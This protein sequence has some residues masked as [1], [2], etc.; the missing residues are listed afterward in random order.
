MLLKQ[1]CIKLKPLT[2]LICVKI[3]KKK[4]ESTRQLDVDTE[5]ATF[6][7][8]AN[9]A[10]DSTGE[11]GKAGAVEFNVDAGDALVPRAFRQFLLDSP[12]V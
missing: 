5:Q 1:N 12:D 10:G 9:G 2:L 4:R 8:G 7:R 6:V 3:K 11:V